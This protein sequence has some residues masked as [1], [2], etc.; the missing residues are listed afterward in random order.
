MYAPLKPLTILHVATINKPITSQMGYGPI[1]T[2]IYNIDKGLHALGHR[3]IVACSSDSSVTGE[4]YTTVSKTLGDY[5]RANTPEGQA[6]T[7]LHLSRALMRAERG[8]IDIVHMHEWF[9]R[10]YAGS[11]NPCVPIVTTLHVPGQHSGF[12]EYHERHPDT[13]HRPLLHCIAISDYQKLQYDDLIQVVKT[14]PHGID[15]DDY[16]FKQESNRGS[17]LFSIGRI[18]SVKGQDIAIDVAKRAGAQ[19][20][21]AGCIQDKQEDRAFFARLKKSINLVVDVS[22]YPVNADYYEAVMKP[23]LS[24][25]KQIIY[26]GELGSAAKKHWYRHAQATLFPIQWGEPFGMVLIESMASGTPI[27]A[28]GEGA[29]PEIVKHGETGFVVGSVDAMVKAVSCLDQIDRR[30]CWRHVKTHF[31]IRR[32]AEG[33]AAVYAQLAGMPALSQAEVA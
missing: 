30:S 28:F 33:Y 9:E 18:T 19:L 12:T 14:V 32:M 24:S 13:S 23:I 7:D 16:Q 22:R 27:L 4:K 3:S 6:H 1:E 29:V 25:K 5:W 31:S 10:V 8:D 11:F 20:I 2:V 15:V 26:V 17:Y 21:L